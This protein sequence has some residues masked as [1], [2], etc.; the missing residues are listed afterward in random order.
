MPNTRYGL[1][2]LGPASQATTTTF[3]S[4]QV[5]NGAFVSNVGFSSLPTLPYSGVYQGSLSSQGNM[6]AMQLNTGAYTSPNATPYLTGYMRAYYRDPTTCTF[7]A[8]SAVPALTAVVPSNLTEMPGNFLY[9]VD[10]QMV[11]LTGSNYF[12]T[13]YFINAFLQAAN[14]ASESNNYSNPLLVAE[15]TSLN[16]YGFS[17]YAQWI[18]QGLNEYK[19]GQALLTAFRNIGINLQTINDGLN[20]FATPNAVA[21]VMIDNGLGY[22]GNLTI[23]LVNAGID[24]DDLYNPNYTLIIANEL[25]KITR[26]TDLNTIQAVLSSSVPNMK[27]P[28]DYCSIETASGLQNDSI[29]ENFVQA[30]NNLYQKAPNLSVLSGAE[31]ADLLESLTSDVG[32]GVEA[33]A[34]PKSLLPDEV[35]EYLKRILPYQTSGEPVTFLNV[36][37]SASGYYL[38]EMQDIN[39][40]IGLLENTSYGPLIK[41]SLQQISYLSYTGG[42]GLN[43]EINNYYSILTSAANDPVSADIVQTI[44]QKYLSVCEK[45]QLEYINYNKANFNVTTFEENAQ[46]LAFVTSIPEF[47]QDTANIDTDFVIYQMSSDNTAGQCSKALVE[48]FRNIKGMANA[49]IR[50]TSL[51]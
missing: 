34:G 22:I 1:A 42:P 9:Y 2:G 47:S 13:N 32:V 24:L 19:T 3:T 4:G 21:K 23:N 27:N 16:Y 35:I 48:Q 20:C 31:F 30:G 10:L 38:Q 46:V 44:N 39:R 37:G 51:I 17:S 15:N 8:N 29:F 33:L 26:P 28:L 40:Y 5:E 41:Q 49:A 50:I 18:T 12:N 14:W 25:S 36:L 43:A 11:R 45:L 6:V 7:G